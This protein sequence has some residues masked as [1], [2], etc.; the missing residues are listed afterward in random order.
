M[1][2]EG[3][4]A[5][6][7]NRRIDAIRY[8]HLA[9]GYLPPDTK[10]V[11]PLIEG[12]KI[13]YN[14]DKESKKRI[15]KNDLNKMLDRIPDSL[16][17]VRD[18]A[19]LLLGYHGKLFREEMVSLN[20]EN[21]DL[22]SSKKYA[23][24]HYK[25]KRGNSRTYDLKQEYVILSMEKR[26][27]PVLALKEWLEISGLLTGPLFLSINKHGHISN[28]PSSGKSVEN[29]VKE[30]AGRAGMDEKWYSSSSFK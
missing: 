25:R 9:K 30:Y 5:S 20:V 19:L 23:K 10:L 13:A 27:C 2:L 12:A 26:K 8:A 6:T 17:G 22:V 7:I 3:Y 21:L 11:Q 14:T 4:K 1:V 18:K 24:V 16:K 28:S 29:I 15:S